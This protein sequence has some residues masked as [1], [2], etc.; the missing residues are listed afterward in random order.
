MMMNSHPLTIR[1]SANI[2]CYFVYYTWLVVLES[3]IF[4]SALASK[5]PSIKIIMIYKK[6][7]FFYR[8]IIRNIDCEVT[9]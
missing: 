5:M 1:A 6:D 7:L 2:L 4:L 3:N 8:G 9:T